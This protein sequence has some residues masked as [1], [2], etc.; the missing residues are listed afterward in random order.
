MAEL[1]VQMLI[2]EGFSAWEARYSILYRIKL[3]K[4]KGDKQMFFGI[5]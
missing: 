2:R 1:Y 5:V 4:G 3:K